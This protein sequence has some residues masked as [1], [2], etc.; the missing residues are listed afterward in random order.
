MNHAEVGYLIGGLLTFVVRS[1]LVAARVG[2]LGFDRTMILAL[3]S[4]MWPLS[5]LTSLASLPGRL[6]YA[7]RSA[8]IRLE[9][10]RRRVLTTPVDEMGR[11]VERDR[12]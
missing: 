1:S 7:N 6:V 9:D 10:E 3:Y 11:Q 12:L 8:K 2:R 5:L 4:V